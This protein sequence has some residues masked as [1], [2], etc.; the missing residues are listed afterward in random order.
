MNRETFLKELGAA[1]SN[2]SRAE[3]EEAVTYYD[4]M[5][6]DAV[7]AG[8]DEETAVG[9]LG[10]PADVA[11][12]ILDDA[13]GGE[14]GAPEAADVPGDGVWE[15]GAAVHT[16]VVDAQDVPVRVVPGN[17]PVR[18]R[19]TPVRG[20]TVRV[21]EEDGIFTFVQR[22]RPFRHRFREVRGQE[23]VLELPASFAGRVQVDTSNA[24]IGAEGPWKF[25]DIECR[26]SNA[27]VALAQFESGKLHV[28]TSN[29]KVALTA[30]SGNTCAAETSNGKICAEQ[31]VFP[32]QLS[33]RTSN[34]KIE[35][36]HLRSDAYVLKTSN[37]K[38]LASLDADAH[39]YTIHSS[40][41]NAKS[42]LPTDWAGTQEGKV[43][44][45]V[46]SNGKIEVTFLGG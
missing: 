13:A 11:R 35:G 14:S 29:A 5:I 39:A 17:G 42:N 8:Q 45:A 18:V 23:I 34:A 19:F 4:E 16:V 33:L 21:N 1:L 9:R 36:A 44:S 20:E 26:T 40:T 6:R 37:A 27:S 30:L 24:K 32:Q 15:A 28:K 10:A 7:E 3:R 41:S 22:W 2:L 46:T 31:L 12:Q 38:I 43:L 25:E